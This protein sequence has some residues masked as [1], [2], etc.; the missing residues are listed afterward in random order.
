MRS[1]SRLG[2]LTSSASTGNC[3]WPWPRIKI[4]NV[5]RVDVDVRQMRLNFG[6]R[7]NRARAV[8]VPDAEHGLAGMAE[9]PVAD[10]VQNQR[11][12]YQAA[13]ICDVPFVCKECT[14]VAQQLVEG[15]RPDGERAER[16]AK[17]GMLRRREG[18]VRQAQLPQPAQALKRG[19]IQQAS[20]GGLEFDEMVDRIVNTLHKMFMFC[21]FCGSGGDSGGAAKMR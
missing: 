9:R 5:L 21:G 20:L 17:P 12:A 11:G 15:A 4:G 6:A 16:V 8:F 10:I 18:E 2:P 13:L 19:R 7:Q 14:A 3:D 1:A